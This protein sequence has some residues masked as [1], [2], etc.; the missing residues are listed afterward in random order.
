MLLP[1][2][3]EVTDAELEAEL[4][5]LLTLERELRGRLDQL[6]IS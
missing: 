5:G 6:R 1:E 3:G 2:S 4:Q